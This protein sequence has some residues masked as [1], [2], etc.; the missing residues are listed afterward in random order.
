MKK[1]LDFFSH[2]VDSFDDLKFLALRSVYG[3]EG[4]GRFWALNC[5]IAKESG[6]SLDLNQKFVRPSCAQKLGMS[7]EEFNRFIQFLID[8]CELIFEVTEGVITTKRV[9]QDYQ[10]V[11]QEREASR[12]RVEFRQ[13]LG[14]STPEKKEISGEKNQNKAEKNNRVEESREEK[15]ER[16][17]VYKDNLSNKECAHAHPR[18]VDSSSP[19]PPPISQEKSGYGILKNVILSPSE[20]GELCKLYRDGIVADYINRLGAHL[21]K[22]GKTYRSHYAAILDWLN[23]DNVEQRPT[24]WSSAQPDG[25]FSEPSP[26]AKAAIFEGAK[27][28]FKLPTG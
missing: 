5:I 8:E 20:H 10:R 25:D 11:N 26:E 24:S 7:L 13:N 23:R 2:D 3:W 6:C 22:T 17:G 18:I 16:E 12:K 14:S 19:P 27:A 15:K 28:K 21:E 1:N 4:E 9:Q